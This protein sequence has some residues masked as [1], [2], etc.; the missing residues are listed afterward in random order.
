[1]KLI[2]FQKQKEYIENIPDLPASL[3]ILTWQFSSF[4]GKLSFTINK[5]LQKRLLV[6]RYF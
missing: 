6:R 4:S 5:H 2:L 1:M 3:V